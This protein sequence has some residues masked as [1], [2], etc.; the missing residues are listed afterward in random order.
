MLRGMTTL[1]CGS[2]IDFV[3]PVLVDLYSRTF[4]H[5]YISN[6]NWRSIIKCG[7]LRV[8]LYANEYGCAQAHQFRKCEIC[9]SE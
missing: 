9:G 8:F 6:R 2:S 4:S 5:E 7:N 1:C 3:C